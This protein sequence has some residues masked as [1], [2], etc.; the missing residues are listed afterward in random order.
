MR[1]LLVMFLVLA[2]MLA[3][4]TGV[5]AA[6][7]T[8]M[9]PRPGVIRVKLQ[10]E[11]AR[12]VG[13]K[14]RVRANGKLSVGIT[15]LDRAA[16][17]AKAVS[18]RP[19]LPYSERF[20]AQRA[21]YGL[22]RWYVVEFDESVSPDDARKIFGSTAGVEVSEAIVPM[23]LKE[24]TG[25][26][27]A[28]TRPPMKATAA[29]YR[30]ND[31][32]L[33]EQWH[34]QNFGN[35]GTAVK[36][37]DIN[38][39]EAWNTTTGS[40]DVIVAIIDGG[41]DYLHEDLA[42]NMWVNEAELNGKPGEDNDNNGYVG[43]IYGYN[44]CTN[45]GDIYPHSHGTHVAGTVSAVNNNGI[46]VAGVAGGDGTP[47]TGVRLMSCQVF[48]SR[49]G[50]GDGDF[51]SA[52]VYACENGA[53]I[54]Q[55][56]WGWD[57]DGY[58]EQA[59][60]DAIDYFTKEAKSP[61]MTGGLCI[62]AAGNT[63]LEGE[64]YPGAYEPVVAV[65]SM[66]NELL[67]A[68]YS[69][70]GSW[71]DVTAPGGLLDYASSAGVLSTLP[72]N[73]YG[74]N[75]GTS[76]ATPHVS[77]IAALILSKYG[78]PTFINESLRTQLI[79]SVNDFYGYA[80]NE[81][82][83]G[84][85]GSGYIDAAKALA[86]S[87][88]SAPESVGEYTIDAAQD[89][90]VINWTIPASNDNN[91][92]H[93]IIYY[94]KEPFT[95]DSDLS[96]LSTSVADT[97][98]YNSGDAVQHEIR[99]LNPLTKYYV[100]IQAV[101]RWGKAAKLSEVKEVTTNAGPDM[102]V[103][104]T[105]LTMASTAATPKATAE[106]TIGNDDDGI[107]NWSAW[108]R[109]LSVTPASVIRPVI[110][111]TGPYSGK[112]AGNRIM[113]MSTVPAD[114]NASEYPVE[115]SYYDQIYA[116]IG[117][118]DRTLP[119]SMAQWFYVNP[120]TYPDGF[121]L[122]EIKV[123]GNYGVNPKIQIYRGDLAISKASLI[124]DVDVPYFA[125]GYPV[126]LSEQLYFAPGE[127]FWVTIH[128]DGNQEGYPL[129]MAKANIGGTA[130]YSF[131]SNDHGKTWTQLSE[132]LRGSSYE[133]DAEKMTW[134]ITA[135]S[136][137]PD[138]SSVIEMAPA[139]GTL[140]KGETQKVTVSADGTKF[141]NGTYNAVV[142]FTTNEGA[143]KGKDLSI[144]LTYTVGG[145]KSDV[146]T[147]KIVDF[148]SILVGQT[149]TLKVEVFNRGY[150]SFRGS[151]Y[152]AGLYSS[153]ITSTSE[154]FQGPANG[155]NSGFPARTKV[156]FELTFAPK[157]AGSQTGSIVFTDVD[158]NTVRI[159]VQG[160][161]TDPAKLALD[162]AVVDGGLLTVGEP[163]KEVSFK[164]SNT[165]K[166]PLEYVFP[167]FSDETIE[168][169][170]AKNH[171]FGYTVLSTLEGYGEF[172][173]DGN[174]TMVGGVNIASQFT[175]S[176]QV[177]EPVDIGFSF[178]YYGNNYEQ[179]Y[180][181][182]FGGIMF[183]PAESRFRS[184]LTPEYV[185]GTGYISAF[186]T[187]LMMNPDSKVEYAMVDGKF[188][189]NFSNVLAVVYDKEY[190]PV[191]FRI[192]LSSNGDI[193]IFYDD[194]DPNTVFQ[195][196]STMFCGINDVECA[197]IVALTYADMAN[198][199][200]VD[201]ETPDNT[202]YR[203]F[204]TGTAVKFE[205]PKASFVKSLSHPYGIVS[206][207][208]EVEVKASIQANATMN[209]GATFNHLA[210]LT[211]DPAPEYGYVRIEAT[212]AG[213]DLKPVAE[214]VSKNINVGDVFRTADVKVPV[215]IKN[216][217]RDVL[218]VTSIGLEQGNMQVEAMQLPLSVE[219]G[220]AKDII[221]T[222]PTAVE[223]V[224]SDKLNIGTAVGSLTVE[225]SAK[226]I[227]CPVIEIGGKDD[228]AVSA[229]AGSAVQRKLTVS[230][231]GN[232]T[233]LYSVNPDPLVR[234]TL[235]ENAEATTSYK[236]SS[237]VDDTSVKCEWVDIETNGLGEHHNLNYYMNHDF[238]AVELPFEFPF[239]GKKYSTMY[240]YNTGFVSFTKR[241]DDK[242]W[243]EPPGDFPGG[244]VYNNIIAPY[245]GLHSMDQ[246]PTAGTYHYVDENRAVVS[247]M[248]YGNSMNIG[249]C[250]QLILEKDGTFK[251]QY[252]PSYENAVI[253][254]IFGL[255]GISNEDAT[256]S[257]RLPERYVVFNQAV[258]FQPI[259]EA[260]L[261]PGKSEEIV[262][263]FDTDRMAGTYE[264]SLMLTTNQPGYEKMELPM[265]LTLSGEAAPSWPA[266]FVV[267]RTIGYTDT[268][269]SNP[270]VQMGAMY[271]APFAV[272]NKGTA[273]FTITGI[274]VGG[275]SIHDD[276]F[277][278]D[279]PVFML[280]AYLPER[281]GMT[282]E[283]TGNKMWTL[284]D[285]S[286]ITVGREPVKFSIPMMEPTIAGTVGRSEI[287]VKFTYVKAE[288]EEPQT[289]VVNVTFDV[290]PAPAMTFDRP[291]ISIKARTDDETG[292]ETLV[293]SNE[294]EYRLD[295]TV[296]LDPTGVGEEI[297]LPD[298]GGGIAP[299]NAPAKPEGLAL[300][301][302]SAIVPAAGEDTGEEE[303]VS[304]DLPQDFQYRNAMYYPAM[305]G[306]KNVYNYG[307]GSLYD[308]FKIAVSFKAG[309]EGFNVSHIY[310]PV[311]TGNIEGEG[312]N[313]HFV[314]VENVDVNFELKQGSNPA[315][316]DVIGRARL[317]I[318]S[319][320]NPSGMFYVI[321]L[322]KSV[323]MAPGEEFCVVASF[324]AGT[325]APIFVM[326]KEEKV[327]SGRYM[328]WVESY[329]WYDVGELFEQQN[330]SMGYILTCL[331]TKAGSP[332]ISLDG[333]TEETISVEPDASHS[334]KLQYN[335]ATARMEKGNKAVLVVK[336]NDPQQPLV[337]YEV[338]L[339]LNGRPVIEGPTSR[340]YAKEG[341]TTKV[342]LSVS[343]PDLDKLN[344]SL[345]DASGM[346]K[347]V[348][349]EGAAD[350]TPVITALEDGSFAV[351]EYTKPV[352]A[353][354]EIAPDY[355]DAVTGNAFVL[356][357]A[358]AAGKTSD[359]SVRYDIEHVNRAP[360]AVEHA[361]VLI[362]VGSTSQVLPYA[363]L[364][365]DPDGDELSYTFAFTA[366]DLAEAYT[367]P[368]GVIFFG[369]KAG[370]A[371]AK[372]TATDPD[373]LSAVAE[374]EVEVQDASGIEGV[375][376]PESGL[377]VMP[378]PVEDD[379]NAVC[380]FNAVDVDFVLY[381]VAGK[382]V[383]VAKADV[384]A[385][386]AVVIPV[387][388]LPAGHYVLTAVWAEGSAAARVVKR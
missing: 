91:V 97:K 117:D 308:E 220:H 257:I 266:D 320:S 203:Y 316:G 386:E 72:N 146:V 89:Y 267:E 132:A 27:T 234:M 144:P 304:F 69:T 387:A 250:F 349:V 287:P 121:N 301:A 65:A 124:S 360:V 51:A 375:E 346:A 103:D 378:N 235:P 141:V 243:P 62:F 251:F 258:S 207:G 333:A 215:T 29:D 159:V 105:R 52:L 352:K 372:V 48:D 166:Y 38:L 194:Y 170:T 176:K 28:V 44:F 67:P 344:I 199:W 236:Y 128:F 181:T 221:V 3:G 264:G 70:R 152:G 183:T 335:A 313:K 84:K 109:T 151:K 71:V 120:E 4:T 373:G 11:V 200:G 165:G 110:G 286:P 282:G 193:E 115:I 182:S 42:A 294:G 148:G 66:T 17:T 125:Y 160:S 167:K 25:G 255:A 322:E 225:L 356:T 260:P 289:K 309:S 163:A 186:G 198:I 104:K 302:K 126:T 271:D 210:I 40:S 306:N 330:G 13:V 327:V 2:S 343:D 217:G 321:P 336:S 64:Y 254:G 353:I 305:P 32:R 326:P 332:W 370:K 202:R 369:K 5:Y 338:T 340:V 12:T 22:D 226:V 98:F 379:L 261:A 377:T 54:A 262:L 354:V 59:V 10:P 88:G 206:P 240:V 249:V 36:G 227:G 252:K 86:L 205:A 383:A 153:N 20:A 241:N 133:A 76:M 299:M 113:P 295:F 180:I 339:D 331:E 31:P 130:P 347:L 60:L 68:S 388:S 248:E 231:K 228:L 290:T 195:S 297:T 216:T 363:E 164:I 189:V 239:Y 111:H 212:I 18:I 155:I 57:G 106:F 39:F 209:A 53:T 218:K 24:G 169:S 265:T 224:I 55:C 79:T 247:F 26:F 101:N 178:P 83:R 77:G 135:R 118:S 196:G 139:S 168:G 96:G 319:Q 108:K 342:D 50:S 272:A 190:I 147:P 233:L 385:G 149:K 204:G 384:S 35:I 208:E 174:P 162:P 188:M 300:G 269:Q 380:G 8:K 253:F 92:H 371:T 359:F 95:A 197:D 334:L 94:S 93:H 268:D 256:S 303:D 345:D 142:R 288:G 75:E 242:L 171:K 21:K 14:P 154:H 114:Y 45:S 81:S 223:G 74:F 140:R 73:T 175:D 364:F 30:F 87:D 311:M 292:E 307:S 129:C 1:K 285:G 172:A 324:P 361:P 41:I 283:L 112:M 179:A 317:F 49:S 381:D 16:S 362:G 278:E 355:G 315:A 201:E 137:N 279:I 357:A 78:S 325:R 348:K 273:E 134:A 280:L 187:Q 23:S 275:P 358:D 63:G 82:V 61:N 350:D 351:E 192:A 310:M 376:A 173:Y 318:A 102:T 43:D 150:G 259:V 213:D 314:P 145:N 232:E 237:S 281:N 37:A 138:W 328:A 15:P 298:G 191:S 127:A 99:N 337:N 382:A 34:Y 284:Y 291:A 80:D 211:N 85:F 136:T 276:F 270:I 184:P 156:E 367:T 238:V 263:D 323:Y 245:W 19:M 6:S 119:N 219:P 161:A 214:V 274:E 116:Y 230:N 368:T 329:G 374:V 246:T 293:I 122:T 312:S 58:Y 143:D 9:A 7:A 123:D 46:G 185:A 47:G 157:A 365:D 366:T 100:A 33:P 107:L 56:S 222:V 158:G 177:S 277:D 90:I 131:M 229:E 244:T 296:R 341:L